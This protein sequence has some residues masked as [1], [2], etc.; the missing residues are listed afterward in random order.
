MAGPHGLASTGIARPQP[1]PFSPGRDDEFPPVFNRVKPIHQWSWERNA[2]SYRRARRNVPQSD[3]SCPGAF[4][5]SA[6]RL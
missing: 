6:R 4:M 5:R 1:S 2:A 3:A